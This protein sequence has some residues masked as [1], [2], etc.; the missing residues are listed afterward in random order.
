MAYIKN[1]IKV[2]V[3]EASNLKAVTFPA[4][5]LCIVP[6]CTEFR[7][8]STKSPSSCEIT[9]K[10]ESKVRIFTTKLTFKSCEQL[11]DNGTPWAY[12]ITTADGV[13]Y[14]IGCDHRP[15]P[16]LTRTENMPNSFTETSLIA[17]TV[18]WSD[19]IKPLQIIE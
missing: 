18:T 3:T 12:R 17:Y 16:V 13:R 14:L 2:E 10:V 11:D 19:V 4:R 5:N 1:I 8:I 7:Q 9:D 15:F 6:S